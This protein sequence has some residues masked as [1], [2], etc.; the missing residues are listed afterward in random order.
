MKIKHNIKKIIWN[1]KNWYFKNEHKIIPIANFIKNITILTF[2]LISFIYILYEL[3]IIAVK[4]NFLI[5]FNLIEYNP[6]DK[7]LVIAQISSTFLTTAVLSLIA[8]IENKHIFGEKETELLFGKKIQGFYIPMFTLYITMIINIILMIN[9]KF[10]NLL[11]LLFFLSVY[12]LI[13]IINKIG[14]IFLTT[15]KYTKILYYKYYKE[16]ENNIINN[17]LPKDYENKLLFNLKD[18]TIGLIAEKKSFI[19][20]KYKYV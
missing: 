9:E 17:I 2:V 11:I 10:A 4:D 1:I 8:S 5:K 15:K 20:E 16:A 18:E 7:D 12:I 6:I 19:Y 3:K 14:V 13:Y